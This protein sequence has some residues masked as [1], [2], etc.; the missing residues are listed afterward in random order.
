MNYFYF[1]P[2][3]VNVF[4]AGFEWARKEHVDCLYL[5]S[6]SDDLASR[7]LFEDSGAGLVDLRVTLA[8]DTA[9]LSASEPCAARLRPA[10]AADVTALKVIASK[11]HTDSRFYSDERFARERCDAL[12]ATWIERSV[13]GWAQAVFVAELDAAVAGYITVHARADSLAEIGLIAVAESARGKGLG[14][15]LV[16][17]A[18]AWAHEAGLPHTSVV[19]QG[20]NVAAQRLYQSAGFRTAR[21]QLWHHLWFERQTAT[22]A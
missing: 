12:Y 20:S 9:P 15:F 18:L 3:A 13:S 10:C 21:V 17:R 2:Y 14:R 22:R 19:T 7:R 8:R 6:E 11:A 16:E 4:A 1:D 5:L